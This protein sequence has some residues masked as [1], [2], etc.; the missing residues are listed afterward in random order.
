VCVCAAGREEEES[1]RERESV[2]W[3]ECVFGRVFGK[4]RKLVGSGS[5]KEFNINRNYMKS[6]YK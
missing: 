1:Q 6:V 5:K 3:E 2:R 4:R